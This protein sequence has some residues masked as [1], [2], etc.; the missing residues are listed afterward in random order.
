MTYRLVGGYQDVVGHDTPLE[1][2][3]TQD[4]YL[5]S[6]KS[7]NSLL[8]KI[9]GLKKYTDVNNKTY[10]LTYVKPTYME[11]IS[12]ASSCLANKLIELD[13]TGLTK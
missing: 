5:N 1:S 12:S 3:I 2:V 7:R 11:D 8:R 13:N 6:K 4:K 10:F 9:L